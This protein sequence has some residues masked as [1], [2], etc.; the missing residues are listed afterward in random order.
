[1]EEV[2]EAVVAAVG[3][4]EAPDEAGDARQIGPQ[5]K[6]GQDGEQPEEGEA[7]AASRTEG[8]GGTS[9]SDPKD[10]ESRAGNF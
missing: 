3:E 1:M 9:P 7:T 4:A 5:A 6:G 10:Q 2:K 8:L